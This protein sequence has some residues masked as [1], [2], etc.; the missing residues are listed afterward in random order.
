VADLVYPPILGLART[1]FL[2]LGLRFVASGGRNLPKSGGAVLVSNHVS[3][4]DFIFCGLTARPSKRLVRFMAKDSTFTHAVSGPL[5]RGMH[6]IPVDR[7][8]GTAAYDHAVAALRD[9][10][11]V[12]VFPEATISRSFE[13]KEFK[14]GAARMA[15][16]A[17]VPL[18]PMATWGGQRIYTKGRRPELS[19]GKAIGIAVGDP[20]LPEPGSDPAAVTAELKRRIGDLLADLQSRYPQQPAGDDDRWWL[21]VRLGGTAPTLEEATA[22]D[23][24]EASERAARRPSAES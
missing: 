4:L 20:Y 7:S 15:L 5:M 8:A 12:G 11:I 1:L 17:G 16:A 6:H 14:T 24:A 9:G 18:I 2:G 13:L 21:P 22:M 10:E 19:R 3:Y 23:A